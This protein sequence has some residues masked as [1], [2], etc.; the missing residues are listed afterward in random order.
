MVLAGSW[1]WESAGLLAIVPSM[2][3]SDLTK[4]VQNKI[5]IHYLYSIL[6]CTCICQI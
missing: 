4:F 1:N 6:D 2:Y 3:N 5:N